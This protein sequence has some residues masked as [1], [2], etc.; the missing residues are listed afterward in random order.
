[1]NTPSHS[2]GSNVQATTIKGFAEKQRA[3]TASSH[4]VSIDPGH[5]QFNQAGQGKLNRQSNSFNFFNS[6]IARERGR[7]NAASAETF[8]AVYAGRIGGDG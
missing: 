6:D 7:P 1:M 4:V 3:A 8:G 2:A 5:G